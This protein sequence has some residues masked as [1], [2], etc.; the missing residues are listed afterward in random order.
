[1]MIMNCVENKNVDDNNAGDNKKN[2][3]YT[4]IGR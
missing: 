1:M 3:A 4:N 2:I